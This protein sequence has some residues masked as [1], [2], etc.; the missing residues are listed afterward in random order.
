MNSE[1]VCCIM[2]K[3][4]E[5]FLEIFE[6]NSILDLFVVEKR[7]RQNLLFLERFQNEHVSVF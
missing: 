1:F 5:S 6:S 7:S 4:V 2:E 3:F